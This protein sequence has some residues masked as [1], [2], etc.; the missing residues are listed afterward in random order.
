MFQFLGRSFNQLLLGGTFILESQAFCTY[1]KKKKL[2]EKI[3]HN[4]KV[5]DLL[6]SD[7]TLLTRLFSLQN[8]KLKPENFTDFLIHEVRIALPAELFP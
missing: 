6:Q 3:F 5:I 1:R 8:I 7:Q 4:F 2:T